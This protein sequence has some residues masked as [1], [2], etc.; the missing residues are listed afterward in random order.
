MAFQSG[1]MIRP[2][3]QNR[4]P[5]VR[6][7][8]LITQILV[9]DDEQIKTGQFGL[10]QQ[11]AVFKFSPSHFHR[12]VNVMPRQCESHLHRRADIQQHLYSASSAAIR[13]QP[14]RSTA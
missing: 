5:P 11:S 7:V 14:W 10:P 8:L 6:K 2:E 12:R 9:A 13:S 1:T 3:F 4:Q